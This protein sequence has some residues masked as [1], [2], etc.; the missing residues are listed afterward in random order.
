MWGAMCNSLDRNT[1]ILEVNSI[2]DLEMI[3]TPI[4]FSAYYLQTFV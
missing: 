3:I 2:G 1:L 4:L